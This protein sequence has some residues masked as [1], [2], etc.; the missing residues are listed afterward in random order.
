MMAPDPAWLERNDAYVA[1]A[2][3]WLRSRSESRLPKPPA[4]PEE[5]KPNRKSPISNFWTWR[6]APEA[7][8]LLVSPAAADA[9]DADARLAMAAEGDPPPALVALGDRF[10]L[11]QFERE[12]LLLAASP[13]LE[14]WIASTPP[15]FAHSLCLF[16]KPNRDAFS[17]DGR[18]R[19]WKLIE[20]LDESGPILTRAIGVDERILN[21]INGLSP[22]DERLA[23]MLAP[24]AL[25]APRPAPK[26]HEAAVAALA[27]AARNNR[28]A[29]L[30]GPDSTGKRNVA[31]LAAEKEGLELFR[32]SAD[33]IPADPV[34]CDLAA[35]L[36][37]RE[38]LLAP[39]GLVIDAEPVEVA[40]AALSRIRRFVARTGGF[41]AILASDQLALKPTQMVPINVSRPTA[42]EQRSAWQSALGPKREDLADRLA[43][44]FD[45]SL[46]D[47][48]LLAQEEASKPDAGPG[49]IWKLACERTHPGTGGRAVRVEAK[50]TWDDIVLPAPETGLLEAIVEQASWRSKVYDSWG[51]RSVMNRGLGISAL[52]AGPSGTGKTMAAEVL[53]NA[54]ELDLFR[55]DLAAVVSKYIGETEKHL[56]DIFDA[57]EGAGAVLLFD[58]ADALFGKRNEAK[59]SHDR[60]ANIETDYLLQRLENYAGVAIL[61]TNMR[62]ALDSAFT[63]RL[64]FVVN[65]PY[66]G[67]GDRK[68]IWERAFPKETPTKGLDFE[69][70]SLL[71]LSGGDIHMVALHASFAAAAGPKQ[72]VTMELVFDAARRELRK[73]DRPINEADFRT[74]QIARAAS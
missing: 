9:S 54:L 31:L 20:L 18:L 15:T 29:I 23:P 67:P 68:R 12:L 51:F 10:G 5:P 2:M 3:A 53:A 44:Q 69:R 21:E 41:V 49:T 28:V 16:D 36:W 65:F 71:D 73:L 66:P 57:L 63:R 48:A 62:G 55:V 72:A 14:P 30:S 56:R 74:I 58:E 70:L 32:I 27:D 46:D 45:L 35:R 61:A 19:H 64:R 37:H 50:A 60:Y 6:Q 24:L 1:A 8:P 11:S 22:I 39:L 34:E 38:T 42:A 4:V 25:E 7:M 43:A 52:F 26:S 17:P 33:A 40:D 13:D 47:I 59:D